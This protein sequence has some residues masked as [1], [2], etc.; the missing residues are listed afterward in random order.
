MGSRHTH[1][2]LHTYT[3]THAHRS[4]HGIEKAAP[5]MEQ[6]Q[7]RNM[8]EELSRREGGGRGW[9]RERRGGVEGGCSARWRFAVMYDSGG[10]RHRLRTRR[11]AE[12]LMHTH[13]HARAHFSS[14]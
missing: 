14:T 3:H 5:C 6:G 1:T 11:D 7:K 9:G 12:T 4:Q 2:H 8:E 10:T 13:P